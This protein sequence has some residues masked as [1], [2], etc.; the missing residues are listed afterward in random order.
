MPQAKKAFLKR[1]PVDRRSSIDRRILDMG[2]EDPEIERRENLKER[3]KGWE[4][5]REWKRIGKWNS[6]PVGPEIE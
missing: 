2:P 3:R 1:S 6:S 5:R 4:D